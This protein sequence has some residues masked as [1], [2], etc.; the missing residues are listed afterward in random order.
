MNVLYWVKSFWAA[1]GQD[2]LKKYAPFLNLCTVCPPTSALQY[3]LQ[4]T[5]LLW[6]FLSL[7]FT[8]TCSAAAH[9]SVGLHFSPFIRNVFAVTFSTSAPLSGIFGPAPDEP[10]LPKSRKRCSC[11]CLCINTLSYLIQTEGPGSTFPLLLAGGHFVLYETWKILHTTQESAHKSLF[12]RNPF[13][14]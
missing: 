13:L 14:K 11:L 12:W 5:P 7:L 9:P 8:R 2:K 6:L 1:R 10:H 3:S 4:C